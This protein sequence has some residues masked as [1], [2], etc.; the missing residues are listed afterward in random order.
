MKG[1]CYILLNIKYIL[2]RS[3]LRSSLSLIN[4][5]MKYFFCQIKLIYPGNTTGDQN[6]VHVK[7]LRN[8]DAEKSINVLKDIVPEVVDISSDVL[9]NKLKNSEVSNLIRLTGKNSRNLPETEIYIANAGLVI[10]HPF[11][12][13]FFSN[14]DLLK[15]DKVFKGIEEKNR[16]IFLLNYIIYRQESYPEHELVLNKVLCGASIYETVQN[17]FLIKEPEIKEINSLLNSVIEHWEAL[18]N[19]SA[20]TLINAF[21]KRNGKLVFRIKHTF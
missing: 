11:L 3:M 13:R 5:L 17:T 6:Q 21:I 7:N 8:P 20:D 1:N 18:K 4:I 19:T 10:L 9:R 2:M 15:H 12:E 16:A 14:I